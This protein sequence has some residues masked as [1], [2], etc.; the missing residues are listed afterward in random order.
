MRGVL[1]GALGHTASD[2]KDTTSSD[3]ADVLT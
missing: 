1:G 2:M 3:E